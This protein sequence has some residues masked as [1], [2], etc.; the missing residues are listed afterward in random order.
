MTEGIPMKKVV[1][2]VVPPKDGLAIE[3]RQG[4]H[5]RVIDLEG[6]QVVDMVAFNLEDLRE[7]SSTSYT[8]NRYF[9]DERPESYFPRDT[10]TTGDWVMSN[11]C[12][13]LMT[14][15]EET[16]RVKGVH[17]LHHRMCNRF[18]YKVF[19]GIDR[20]GCYEILVRAVEPYGLVAADIP[21]SIDLFMNYPHDC[22]VGHY[23]I[24]EPITQ[25]G[26]YVEFRAEMDVLVAMSNCPEDTL[27][28]CN[29]GRCT[30]VK[31]ELYED[32]AY[33]RTEPLGPDEWLDAEI[34]KRGLV[35]R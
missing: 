8:R 27:T 33:E 34:A 7:K 15:V 17:G 9:P 4:Q 22:G 30:P 16:P 20:D 10:V 6:Q 21:D 24:Q 18:F 26:D 5:L 28:P 3:V 12:R 35:V 19:G 11:L 31:V 1:E 29:G 25:P 2:Q 32:A 14:I 23:T 13:P